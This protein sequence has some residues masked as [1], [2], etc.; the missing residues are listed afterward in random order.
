MICMQKINVIAKIS[1][2]LCYTKTAQ[3]IFKYSDIQYSSLIMDIKINSLIYK[4]LFSVN[5]YGSYKLSKNSPFFGPSCSLGLDVFVSI[6]VTSR[7]RLS[8]G[9]LRGG[10]GLVSDRKSNVSVSCP[11]VSFA[12]HFMLF[13]TRFLHLLQKLIVSN[14]D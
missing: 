14:L 2:Y 5:I 11:N 12:C 10:L 13:F 7:S 9:K 8:L 3:R 6:F 4:M 1:C